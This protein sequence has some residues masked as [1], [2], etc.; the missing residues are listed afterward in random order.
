[1]NKPKPPQVEQKNKVIE[2]EPKIK[3]KMGRPAG[4]KCSVPYSNFPKS[5]R[6]IELLEEGKTISEIASM[7]FAS[8]PHVQR[9]KIRWEAEKQG[10]TKKYLVPE[11][12]YHKKYKK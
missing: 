1:V 8:Y 12:M 11:G 9:V 5:K 7:N 10:I 2:S 4:V 6:I 3:K